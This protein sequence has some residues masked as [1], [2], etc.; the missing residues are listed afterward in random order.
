MASSLTL[1]GGRRTGHKILSTS[2]DIANNNNKDKQSIN[3]QLKLANNNEQSMSESMAANCDP[4][5]SATTNIVSPSA[6]DCVR[7]LTEELP[8]QKG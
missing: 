5:E 7:R 8:C 2:A 6:L 3:G 4:N 1:D